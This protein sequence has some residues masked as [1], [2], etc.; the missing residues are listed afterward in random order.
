MPELPQRAQLPHRVPDW[1][2][3]G[4]VFFIT[5]CTVQRHVNTLATPQSGPALLDSF[6]HYHGQQVWWGHLLVLM[7]DHMHALLSVAPDHRLDRTVRAWKS[8][9]TQRIGIAW[10]SGFFDHRIRDGASL[11]EKAAY[12]RMN[13]VRAGLVPRPEDWPWTWEPSN[14]SALPR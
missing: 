11:D 5:I 12:I 13:P 14:A 3:P 9:Q 6:A 2:K 7:P 8:Y 4:A 1:V 10:Q